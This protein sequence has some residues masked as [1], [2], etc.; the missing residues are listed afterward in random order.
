MADLAGQYTGFAVAGWDVAAKE[1]IRFEASDSVIQGELERTTSG[2]SELSRAVGDRIQQIVHR[3]P[4]KG[5]EAQSLA[6]GE[7]R[8]M[9]RRFL[10]GTLLANADARLRVGAFV[11]LDGLGTLFDGKYYITRVRHT[12]RTSSGLWSECSVERPGIGS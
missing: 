11:D 1:G 4:L 8:R 3:V 10:R 12:F 7:F 2:S 6:E 9:A 5:D